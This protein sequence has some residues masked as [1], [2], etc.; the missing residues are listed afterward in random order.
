MKT[1]ETCKWWRG[2]Y[3]YGNEG[4]VYVMEIDECGKLSFEN[5]HQIDA[6]KVEI[7]IG[8]DGDAAVRHCTFYTNRDFGCALHKE[9]GDGK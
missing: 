9:R 8:L 3:Y 1:C 7:E 2:R 4:E 5:R 6:D